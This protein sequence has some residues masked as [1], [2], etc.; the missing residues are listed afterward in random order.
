[1]SKLLIIGAAALVAINA[2]PASAATLISENFESGFGVFTPTGQAV[3]A[4]G[5][6]YLSCCGTSGSASAMANYFVTF[7]SGNEPS[8]NIMS[9]TFN[10]VLGS[11]YTLS[12]DFAAL[13][14]GSETLFFQVGSDLFSVTPTANNNLDTTFAS[15]SFNFT[16]TGLPTTLTIFSSGIA[17]VDAIVDNISVIDAVPEPG[18]WAMLLLGFA[19]IGFQMRRRRQL[20]LATA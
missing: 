17:N 10:T 2:T 15:T 3:R 4:T 5:T 11:M 9:T 6:D 14:T 12:F 1:M 8:G 18:V 16:G 20:G 7:G 13:G 19:G